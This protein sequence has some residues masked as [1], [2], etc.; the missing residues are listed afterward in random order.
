MEIGIPLSQDVTFRERNNNSH[1]TSSTL[2]FLN[3][4][5]PVAANPVAELMNSSLISS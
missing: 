3:Q 5:W 2:D 1:G 4:R